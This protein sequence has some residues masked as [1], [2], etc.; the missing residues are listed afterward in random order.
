MDNHLNEMKLV[1]SAHSA[2]T[3]LLNMTGM[4][5]LIFVLWICLLIFAAALIF[6]V[7]VLCRLFK[8]LKMFRFKIIKNSEILIKTN[9][10]K[11]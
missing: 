11:D 10:K 6:I 4:L 9:S 5:L 1:Q 3:A 7:L 2:K 8:S